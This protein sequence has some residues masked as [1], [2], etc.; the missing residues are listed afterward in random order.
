M[1]FDFFIPDGKGY[2]IHITDSKNINIHTTLVV[3]GFP[4]LIASTTGGDINNHLFSEETTTDE[5]LENIVMERSSDDN[6]GKLVYRF[7]D[8]DFDYEV[9]K[10]R[11]KTI[12]S[13]D[14]FLDVQKQHLEIIESKNSNF[15]IFRGCE[16]KS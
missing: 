10:E 5:I 6:W 8:P 3:E 13:D 14:K 7:Y 4:D 12:L 11:L 16:E 2:P 9:F 1:N 15:T